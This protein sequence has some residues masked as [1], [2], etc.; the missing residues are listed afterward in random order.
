MNILLKFSYIYFNT[1]QTI[2]LEDLNIETTLLMVTSSIKLFQLQFVYN[3]R[4]LTFNIVMLTSVMAKT[5]AKKYV[6]IFL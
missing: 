3:T 2:Y 5:D 1:N 4:K 6:V